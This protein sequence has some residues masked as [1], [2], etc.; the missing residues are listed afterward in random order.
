MSAR[1]ACAALLLT[2]SA[3][4]TPVA[5]LD[6]DRLATQYGHERWDDRQGLPQN[7]V[8]SIAQ[9]PTGYLWLGTEEG[10]VRFDGARFT[11]FD[12]QSVDGLVSDLG[13]SLLVRADGSLWTGGLG[14]VCH[15][16]ERVADCRTIGLEGRRVRAM[17]ETPD[18]TLHL[19]TDGAVYTL[20]GDDRLVRILD[21]GAVGLAVDN[22]GNLVAGTSRG[23]LRRR[24]GTWETAVSG[25]TL[26]LRRTGRGIA[27]LTEKGLYPDVLVAS[28]LDTPRLPSGARD[29]LCDEHGTWWIAAREGAFRI[30]RSGL[31]LV[32]PAQ[33]A[34]SLYS[35]DADTLWVGTAYEG[36]HRLTDTLFVPYGVP[37][38]LSS[39][40]A[41]V[42]LGDPNGNVWIGLA[43]GTVARWDGDRFTEYPPPPG[44]RLGPVFD[45]AWSP[46][47]LFVVTADGLFGLPRGAAH[48]V[49]RSAPGALMAIAREDDGTLWLGTD[50]GVLRSEHVPGDGLRAWERYTRRDGLPGDEVLH[51][52]V[53]GGRVSVGTSQGLATWTGLGFEL[54]DGTAGKSVSHM[55]T[56]GST[57]WV[58]TYGRELL[59]IAEGSTVRIELPPAVIQSS[60]HR[61]L[62][63]GH[64]SLWLSSNRGVFRMPADSLG[65]GR[66]PIVTT[67][68]TAQGMRSRECN[69]P[70]GS[71]AADGSL[72]FPTVR[73]VMR[74]DPR[75]AQAPHR[76]PPLVIE[77]VRADGQPVSRGDVSVVP[78][79]TDTLVIDYTAIHLA[80]ADLLTFRY[81][82]DGYD[83]GWVDAGDRRQAVYTH[84]P[85]GEHTFHVEVRGAGGW[86]ASTAA[87]ET[88]QVEALVW[89]T[90]WFRIAAVVLL[91]AALY[92]AFRWRLAHL[93]AR[94]REL[95]HEV[96]ERTKHLRDAQA[97]LV[98][99]ERQA[100]VATL[101]QGIAH[102]LNN[103]LS[104]IAG[105]VR[106]LRRYAEHL[107][108]AARTLADG[109]PR[110][111]AEARAVLDY[112]PKRRDLAWLERD[113]QSLLGD[114]DEGSRRA[115]LIVGDLQNLTSGA[116]RSLETVDL[117]RVIAQTQSIVQPR[118]AGVD[119]TFQTG[120]APEVIARAGQLEQALLNLV[121]NALR[122]LDGAGALEVGAVAEDDHVRVW[123]RDSG[124][125]MSDEVRTR[126][127]EP[128]F[129]TRAAGDGHG[130]GLAIVASIVRNHRGELH[131]ESTPGEGTLA[132]FR[133]PRR[134][135]DE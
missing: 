82:L 91:I 105:N 20:A 69:G 24:G 51:L 103:P 2:G 85:P 8:Y 110:E 95:E 29:I 90:V 23:V 113:V 39:A 127:L 6:P 94:Q 83:R 76:P 64:G 97:E 12:R 19:S 68:G 102:E 67:F 88:L 79:G 86:V 109:H 72:W 1:A 65:V 62:D 98:R 38:G 130:L 54:V 92:G 120:E 87:N 104:F 53:D 21:I 28:R 73:G 42:T 56:T 5:A 46:D 124:P 15:L 22:A 14:A 52:S 114:L 118:L 33:R 26:A 60:F 100:Q 25:P 11:V 131:L 66:R 10:V 55:L 129:T 121:D 74:V 32:L 123:V 49:T 106:P 108:R 117:R 57:R 112:G 101:V 122:A 80:G 115:K 47:E 17:V 41:L 99:V 4:P 34:M 84:L 126:A 132:W 35:D 119:A 133:V 16:A 43:R 13:A 116:Q 75:R 59:R 37:E 71:R 77:S 58:A 107:L 89:Q 36:L 96:A 3:I 40:V 70:G 63:D 44:M 7:T 9:D 31:E 48:L 18:R 45:L 125:G 81:R 61:V 27:A 50:D 134:G 78:P 128:F 30:G 111:R 135:P 93:R